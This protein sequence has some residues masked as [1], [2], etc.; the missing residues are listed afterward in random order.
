MPVQEEEQTVQATASYQ[1]LND[2]MEQV[3]Q[4]PDWKVRDKKCCSSGKL[5][6]T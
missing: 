6:H 4:R 1:K 3:K 5:K 2:D